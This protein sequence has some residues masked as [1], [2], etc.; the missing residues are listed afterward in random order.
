MRPAC[1]VVEVAAFDAAGMPVLPMP[2]TTGWFDNVLS[3]T[4]LMTTEDGSSGDPSAAVTWK[5]RISS[6]VR[7]GVKSAG[8][9]WI[10]TCWVVPAVAIEPS[11]RAT[12]LVAF[13][14]A[15]S[16]TRGSSG[17]KPSITRPQARAIAFLARPL[18]KALSV[19]LP[20]ALPHQPAPRR[21][22]SGSERDTC[23]A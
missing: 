6:P 8:L 23:P 18:R 9:I 7:V 10:E 1:T 11:K 12:T 14:P 2:V 21:V 13:D 16:M 3:G 5:P 4:K 20:N 15:A 19:K 22:A 17:S